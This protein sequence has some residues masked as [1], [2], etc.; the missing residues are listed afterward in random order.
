VS[1][2]CP[3]AEAN[4]FNRPIG[5]FSSIIP[6]FKFAGA[7]DDKPLQSASPEPFV[8]ELLAL[9]AV[10][11]VSTSDQGND[12]KPLGF[13]LRPCLAS[14]RARHGAGRWSVRKLSPETLVRQSAEQQGPVLLRC[15]RIC[16]LRPR[17]GFEGWALSGAPRWSV[18]RGSGRC[19]HHRAQPCRSH[20]G[21]A[22]QERA[23]NLDSMLPAGKLELT[24]SVG[25]MMMDHLAQ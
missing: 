17:L 7:W 20:N 22:R 21:V 9:W 25:E 16:G 14:C 12:E 13:G 5:G 15:R 19:R 1:D 2:R 8:L 18:D 23:R 11:W 4:A 24:R 3:V 10:G 6:E